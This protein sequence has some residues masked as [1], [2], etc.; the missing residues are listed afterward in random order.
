[1]VVTRLFLDSDKR[2][3][4]MKKKMKWLLCGVLAVILSGLLF[5]CGKSAGTPTAGGNL[6]LTAGKPSDGNGANSSLKAGDRP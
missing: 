4:N 1:M 5:A 2:G 6:S 3:I